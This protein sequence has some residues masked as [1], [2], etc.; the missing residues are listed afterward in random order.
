[1]CSH[2]VAHL[3]IG[4]L[5]DMNGPEGRPVCLAGQINLDMATPCWS[6]TTEKGSF[7]KR[8]Y[9]DWARIEFGDDTTT[10]LSTT[11]AVLENQAYVLKFNVPFT[12]DGS[13]WA[14]EVESKGGPPFSKFFDGVSMNGGGIN[15]DDELAF[16]FN[17]PAGSS[18]IRVSFTAVPVCPYILYNAEAFG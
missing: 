10:T 4:P 7:C 6:C 16:S 14:V 12:V 11:A 5:P 8:F 2:V 3:M 13:S 17:N 9:Q 18:A 15:S 1:V